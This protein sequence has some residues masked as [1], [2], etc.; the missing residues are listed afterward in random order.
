MSAKDH[1]GDRAALVLVSALILM[2][3]FQTD[4]GL[5]RITYL[6]W[7]DV[8]NLGSLAVLIFVLFIIILEH[9]LIEHG[10]A[11]AA[12]GI[13]KAVSTTT[14]V[15]VYPIVFVW[16]LMCGGY[17][18]YS[19]PV[20]STFIVVGLLVTIVLSYLWYLRHDMKADNRREECV[21]KLQRCFKSLGTG[22][23]EL[24]EEAFTAFDVDGSGELD[25]DEVNIPSVP[26][27]SCW[28]M[29]IHADLC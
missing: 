22:F 5:G 11:L 18:S 20:P 13:N 1:T 8:F 29:L 26:S 6:V 28:P 9:R 7:W 16:L 19:H 12:V 14:V 25:L 3:N 15:A 2:V 10:D 4:L 21:H 23:Y 27:D 17:R 24:I